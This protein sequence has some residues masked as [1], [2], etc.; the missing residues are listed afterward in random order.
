[1]VAEIRGL[2]YQKMW[3]CCPKCGK[4]LNNEANIKTLRTIIISS[5]LV[6]MLLGGV[7][8]PLLGFG[9]GGIKYVGK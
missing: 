3:E 8:L 7:A 6:R 4:G 9:L 2:L 1:M 5:G